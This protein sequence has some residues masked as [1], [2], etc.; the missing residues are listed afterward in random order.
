METYMLISLVWSA[1]ATLGLL[2]YVGVV[3]VRGLKGREE[4]E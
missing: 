1:A 2:I 3:V 4:E